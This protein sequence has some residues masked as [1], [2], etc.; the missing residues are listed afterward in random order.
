[1]R[2]EMKASVPHD[3]ERYQAIIQESKAQLDALERDDFP[4]PVAAALVADDGQ[5]QERFSGIAQNAVGDF[6]GG[7]LAGLLGLGEL[8]G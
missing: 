4:R 8:Q 3:P 6:S 5:R 2:R 7:S 1:M